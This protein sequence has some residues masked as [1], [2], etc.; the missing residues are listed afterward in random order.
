MKRTLR[1]RLTAED[2]RNLKLCRQSFKRDIR[3]GKPV[4]HLVTDSLTVRVALAEWAEKIDEQ[5]QRDGL[6]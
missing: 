2:E 4:E 3:G 1:V 5:D 6:D